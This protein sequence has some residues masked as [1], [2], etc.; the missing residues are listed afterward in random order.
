ML[1][2]LQA[3]HFLSSLF[4]KLSSFSTDQGIFE[5]PR[6]VKKDLGF[7]NAYDKILVACDIFSVISL[8]LA[9]FYF[10]GCHIWP[11]SVIYKQMGTLKI[12]SDPRLLLRELKNQS[13]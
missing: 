13:I 3:T 11:D 9:H 6:T 8:F 12:K 10:Q 2:I 7:L 5:I 1:K 4:K